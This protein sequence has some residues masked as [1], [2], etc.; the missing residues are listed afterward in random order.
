MGYAASVNLA[1]IDRA[2]AESRAA[3]LRDPSS[4]YLNERLSSA[5]QDKLQ[6]MRT[7]VLLSSDD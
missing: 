4:G 7:A 6:L 3:L 1:I 5:L 2:I